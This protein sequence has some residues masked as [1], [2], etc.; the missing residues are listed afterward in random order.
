MTARWPVVFAVI[1]AAGCGGGAE[2]SGS[3]ALTASLASGGLIDVGG[4][5]L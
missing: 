2:K 5:H 3:Q 1:L 4:R